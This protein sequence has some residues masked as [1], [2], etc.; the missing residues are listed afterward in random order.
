MRLPPA[1]GS[2]PW[3][4]EVRDIMD[5]PPPW[6]VRSGT[7]LLAGALAILFLMGAVIRYPDMIEARAVLTGTNPVVEVVARR[8]GHLSSLRVKE[9]QAVRKGDVLAII[10]NPADAAAVFALREAL[11]TADRVVTEEG[12]PEPDT[13][14]SDGRLG[15]LQD[16]CTTFISAWR[17]QAALVADD[18]ADRTGALLVSQRQR[19]AEQ[20]KAMQDQVTAMQRDL[21]IAEAKFERMRVLHAR[22]SIS[23]AQL[24]EQEQALLATR[25]DH[26]ALG[27]RLVDE[28]ILADRMERELRE[29][30]HTRSEALRAGWEKVR[31][32]LQQLRSAIDVWEADYVLRAPADGNVAFF[33]FWTDQQYVTQDNHVFLIVPETSSLVARIAVKEGGA[34]KIR[35]GQAVRIRM[36]DYPYK[37]FGVVSGSVQSVS[38]VARGGGYLVQVDV[39][40]PLRSSY[41][42]DL[43][44]RQEMA[45]QASI[46]T[47]DQ[48]VLGRIFA[49]I[50]RAFVHT[51]GQP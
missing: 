21:Q 16:A 51:E 30:R 9:G 49:E 12:K 31:S 19:K 50:R 47:A 18:Y 7:S 17:Q 6:L 2:A 15:T 25:R 43:R 10:E 3:S 29:L 14:R 26:S 37:E 38:T 42:R 39:P 5:R 27:T 28:Q 33:D 34:G 45:G 23:T 32:S 11:A 44:F 20:L 40:W 24:Q 35:Q 41:G 1:P 13:F 8:S 36:D 4:D 46:V 22:D 48:S